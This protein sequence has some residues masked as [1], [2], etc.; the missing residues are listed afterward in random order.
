VSARPT[1][2]PG[3]LASASRTPPAALLAS[4]GLVAGLM[5][6]PFAYLVVRVAGAGEAAL[7]ALVSYRTVELLLRTTLFAATVT[8]L[9]GGLALPL[10]WLATRSDL[11]GRGLW[12]VLLALP[13]VIPTYVG[14]YVFV[15]ALGPRGLLQRALEATFG[16]ERL[17]ELYGFGGAA[18]VLTACTYPYLYLSLRGALA[19]IDV[20]L[21]ESARSLGRTPWQ[22]FRDVVLPQLRPALTAGGLLVALYALSDFGAVALLQFDTFTRAIYVQYQASFD[23]TGAAALSLLLS[24]LTA[25]VLYVEVRT[26]GAARYH[27]STVGVARPARPVALGRWRWPAVLFCGLVVGGA[28]LLP[29]GV[30]LYWLWRGLDQGVRTAVLGQA[31]LGSVQASALAALAALALAAPLAVLAVRFPGRATTLLERVAYAGYALPGI[32]IALSL[33]F[34]G[35]RLVPWLYQTLGMLVL[36]YVIRFLPQAVGAMRSSLLQV[37]PHVEEAAR[38]LGRRP[39]EA[40]REVTL[41]LILPGVM[42]GAALV[43]L[44]TMKELPATLLLSPTGF[45]TLATLAWSAAADG[46]FAEAAAP[47]LLLVVCSAPAL[48]ALLGPA[49]DVEQRAE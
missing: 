47:A 10:A 45:R 24:L 11:P 49:A 40:W 25:T 38:S 22:S 27:R 21:E 34:V 5:L 16:V 4:G 30:L 1:I 42:T 8:G 12:S 41:P 3:A 23:R 7:G 32:V 26:R 44:T 37:G 33:V 35:A 18:A 20:S 13:L 14:G 28:L 31:I 36:A 48:I 46:F 29:V 6:V 9:A 2:V 43:F 19:R 39:L 17:P 15:A